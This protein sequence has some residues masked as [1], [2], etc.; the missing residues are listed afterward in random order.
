M[1]SECFLV[2]LPGVLNFQEHQEQKHRLCTG[3]G[4][5]V[6]VGDINNFCKCTG[7]MTNRSEN[8]ADR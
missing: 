7:R 8:V 4:M 6:P 2:K 5:R 3:R 1:S